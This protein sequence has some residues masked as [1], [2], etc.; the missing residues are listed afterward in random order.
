MYQDDY[1]NPA[2]PNDYNDDEVGQT[3][4]FLKQALREDKGLNTLTRKVQL[5]NG[6]IKNKRI[7]VFTSGGA[8]TRI[9]DAETGEYYPNKVGSKDEDLFFK[10]IIATGECNS[11]NGSNKL[12]YF[13]PHHYEN[14]LYTSVEPERVAEW[15]ATRDKRLKELKKVVQPKFNAIAVK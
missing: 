6:K 8:G 4:D 12:F 10:V 14:H 13:S 2:N 7:K 5:D 15:E 3:R 1:F 9:R 11:A